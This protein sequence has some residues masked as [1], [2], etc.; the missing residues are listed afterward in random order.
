MADVIP[1]NPPAP[2]AGFLTCQVCRADDG[3]FYPVCR[4]VHDQPL[5]VR[6]VCT[7][8]FADIPVSNGFLMP[9]ESREPA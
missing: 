7:E 4:Q 8:C 2:E 3:F 5:L 1:L 6:L 9:P